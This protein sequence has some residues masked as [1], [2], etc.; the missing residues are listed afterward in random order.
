[1]T[2]S[3][4]ELKAA[5]VENFRANMKALSPD[6]KPMPF[7]EDL[8]GAISKGVIKTM[9]Q[10]KVIS[11]ATFTAVAG[12]GKGFTV[13]PSVMIGSALS[14]MRA[15]LGT[16]GGI[17]LRPMI[18]A[19]MNSLAIHLATHTE[20]ISISGFGGQALPPVTVPQIFE[21]AIIKNLSDTARNQMLSSKTGSFLIKAIAAGVSD[22]FNVGVP[23]LVPVGPPPLP[24]GIIVAMF[25]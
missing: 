9:F 24:V 25:Q 16:Q 5:M 13:P 18:E 3:I 17:A 7:Q 2:L 10:L 23:G 14:K 15:M 22:G 21:A 20:I 4:T 19:I 1:M 6:A 8:C 12:E 11:V